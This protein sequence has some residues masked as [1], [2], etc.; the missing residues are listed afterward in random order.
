LVPLIFLLAVTTTAGFQKI[1]HPKPNIGFLAKAAALNEKLPTLEQA[2]QQAESSGNAVEIAAARKALRLNRVEHFNQIVDAIAAA[3][4]LVLVT[5]I[6]FISV[7]EWILLLARKR[8]AELHEAPPVWLPEYALIEG[9]PLKVL[10]L[11]ALALALAR[12]LS[13]EAQLERAKHEATCT[14]CHDHHATL[15]RS[16][17]Q[18][19]YVQVTEARYTG[20]INRC[21]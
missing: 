18:A 19:L 4:F 14:H 10:G 1:L 13:G 2:V 12:E 7:R 20:K 3:V 17:T 11:L 9:R 21:C 6:V 15:S 16:S 8:L 5:A